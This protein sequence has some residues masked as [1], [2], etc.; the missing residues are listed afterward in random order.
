MPYLLEKEFM[1]D[2]G[3]PVDD[4][5]IIPGVEVTTAEGHL[6]CMGATCLI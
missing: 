6:L 1:R 2:D 4:F 5:V 3:R